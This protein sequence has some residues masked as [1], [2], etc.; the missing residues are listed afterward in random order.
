MAGEGR[1]LTRF[2]PLSR[3]CSAPPDGRSRRSP[4][5]FAAGRSKR[6]SRG[7]PSPLAALALSGQCPGSLASECGARWR[8]PAARPRL[9]PKESLRPARAPPSNARPPRSPVLGRSERFGRISAASLVRASSSVRD[10]RSTAIVRPLRSWVALRSM[11]LRVVV[12]SAAISARKAETCLRRRSGVDGCGG[13]RRGA[14]SRSNRLSA[15]RPPRSGRPCIAGLGPRV[16]R[17]PRSVRGR[18]RC[19]CS[20][21]D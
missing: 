20:G 6:H 14:A 4:S 8:P 5:R 18:S 10:M 21:G 9:G 15:P 16:S 13:A 7:P 19:L 2:F 11:R 1:A 3:A 12:A 17:G